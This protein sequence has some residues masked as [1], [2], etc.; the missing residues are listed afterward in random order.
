MWYPINYK[1]DLTPPR[2]YRHAVTQIGDSLL[3]FGGVNEFSE[4]FNDIYL[5][6]FKSRKWSLLLSSGEYPCARTFHNFLSIKNE[7]IIFGGFSDKILNDCRILKLSEFYYPKFFEVEE[8]EDKKLK[9]LEFKNNQQNE[10]NDLK[11]LQNDEDKDEIIKNLKIQLEELKQKYESEVTKNICKICLEQ[12]INT[13]ILDC[14][15]RFVC[16]DCSFHCKS[17]P[18][19]KGPIKNLLKTFN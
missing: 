9:K 14:C 13:I 6:N 3:L 17:C 1:S 2:V 12:E 15:H 5:M 16:Y 18:L 8:E 10:S 19:C 7:I 11:T 4:K